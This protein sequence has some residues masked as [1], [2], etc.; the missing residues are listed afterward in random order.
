[1][2][3]PKSYSLSQET[4]EVFEEYSRNP[5]QMARLSYAIFEQERNMKLRIATICR[6]ALCIICSSVIAGCGSLTSSP[7]DCWKR[8][9]D[10]ITGKPVPEAQPIRARRPCNR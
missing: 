6:L 2:K 10:E 7:T 1:M 9:V 4:P 3:H 8:P 5:R